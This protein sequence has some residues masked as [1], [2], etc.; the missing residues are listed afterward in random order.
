MIRAYLREASLLSSSDFAP[1][2]TI[3]PEA[4]TRAVVFGS[5]IR[6]ITAAN[7]FGL[8]SALRA[9]KAIVFR[10]RRADRFTVATMF[11]RVGIMPDA[12]FSGVGAGV[13]TP[14]AA[15]ASCCVFFS[16]DGGVS[17]PAAP[18]GKERDVGAV[19]ALAW[20]AVEGW[21]VSESMIDTE[22]VMK[23]RATCV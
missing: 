7:R 17:S 12:E 8:Y 15:F 5:R 11:C 9:C 14:L 16:E 20:R 4:K 23:P 21:V 1:V 22:R 18:P 6:M 3:L 13:A 2:T 10:S 19:K